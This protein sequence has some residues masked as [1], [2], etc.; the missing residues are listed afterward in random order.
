MTEIEKL[1]WLD[2]HKDFTS[3]EFQTILKCHHL[4]IIQSKQVL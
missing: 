3:S 1:E 4:T 2:S